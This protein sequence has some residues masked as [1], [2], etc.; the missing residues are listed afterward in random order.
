[1]DRRACRSGT[2]ARLS[3]KCLNPEPTI[4]RTMNSPWSFV[5]PLPVPNCGGSDLR[6]VVR[7]RA[8]TR[9][10]T[11]RQELGQGG[12]GRCRA[13]RGQG[14][15]AP[16]GRNPGEGKRRTQGGRNPEARHRVACAA[17]V[18]CVVSVACAVQR[19]QKKGVEL[20]G[21]LNCLQQPVTAGTPSRP[22]DL[23]GGSSF[24]RGRP[25]RKRGS[26]ASGAQIPTPGPR[27]DEATPSQGRRALTV[28]S[29]R[30][31]TDTARPSS[32]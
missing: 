29:V 13:V 18:P 15:G 2:G 27:P 6:C 11:Q 23:P 17:C 19:R 1:M 10:R 12:Q 14:Y 28:D 16:R 8:G 25:S 24:R 20:P 26:A 31:P 9:M 5:D 4:Q 7:E 21:Q 32:T 3:P 22:G 30:P